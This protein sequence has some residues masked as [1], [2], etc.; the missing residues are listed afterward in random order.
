[1]IGHWQLGAVRI[2]TVMEYFAPTHPP[3]SLFAEFDPRRFDAVASVLPEGSWYSEIGHLT[4]AIRSWILFAG[5]EIILIDAGVGNGKRRPAARQHMMNSLFLS[6]LAAA[7]AAPDRV[8]R[9]VLTHLHGDHVGWNTIRDGNRWVPTFPN[10]RYLFPQSDY[11]YFRERFK[12]GE[13]LDDSF[14]DSVLP[15]V[16]AG[17]ADFVQPGDKVGGGLVA[18]AAFGHSPGQLNYSISSEGRTGIFCGDV[19]HHPVQVYEPDWNTFFCIEP[20]QARATRHALLRR[21]ADQDILLMP[22]HFPPP[23]C[24]T[25]RRRDGGYAFV[26]AA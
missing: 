6:W 7:G 10:A 5:D 2:A 21:A 23:H 1:M 12:R 4:I 3:Q 20:E 16:T 25:I 15:I 17:R 26:P 14:E 22:C 11:D 9:V 24:G 8:T 19:L 13:A 18:E